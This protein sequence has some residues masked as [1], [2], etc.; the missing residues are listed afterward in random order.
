MIEYIFSTHLQLSNQEQ[1]EPRPCA[2][3][4]PYLG[5]CDHSSLVERD[6]NLGSSVWW[7]PVSN[8]VA[9]ACE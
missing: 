5:Y 6:P 2:S 3:G 7:Q 1:Q 8:A 4:F 9:A